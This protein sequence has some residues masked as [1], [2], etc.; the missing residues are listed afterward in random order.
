MVGEEIKMHSREQIE[1]LREDNGPQF[2]C[3]IE[4]LMKIS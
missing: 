2:R 4:L 1:V 3:E